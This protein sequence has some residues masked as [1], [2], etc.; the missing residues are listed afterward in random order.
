VSKTYPHRMIYRIHKSSYGGSVLVMMFFHHC[1][2]ALVVF[3]S[4]TFLHC[5]CFNRSQQK[6]MVH[7]LYFVLLSFDLDVGSSYSFHFFGNYFNRFSLRIEANIVLLLFAYMLLIISMWQLCS[8]YYV[9]WASVRY[10]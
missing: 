6:F 1:K 9:F 10:H 2:M 5:L 3:Y 4:S 7:F 8:S